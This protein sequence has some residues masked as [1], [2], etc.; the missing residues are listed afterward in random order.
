MK[1]LLQTCLG[2]AS[3]AVVGIAVPAWSQAVD[4]QTVTC[5]EILD[6]VMSESE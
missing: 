2:L 3:L 4:M 5:D 6:L 1:S